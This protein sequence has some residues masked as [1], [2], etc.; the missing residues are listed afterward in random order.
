M[1]CKSSSTTKSVPPNVTSAG[2][3]SIKMTPEV[4]PVNPNHVLPEGATHF[5]KLVNS[6][7]HPVARM[8][9]EQ[10]S[11]FVHDQEATLSEPQTHH[12]HGTVTKPLEEKGTVP[13]PNQPTTSNAEVIPAGKAQSDTDG[14]QQNASSSLV[15]LWATLDP[16]ESVTHASVDEVGQFFLHYLRNDLVSRDWGGDFSFS[17]Q[18]L[19]RQGTLRVMAEVYVAKKAVFDLKLHYHA[20]HVGSGGVPA[21][22]VANNNTK[23]NALESPQANAR[24]SKA[25][26]TS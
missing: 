21:A 15:E 20:T 4:P 6:D 22:N 26:S 7:C 14:K 18:G 12:D 25:S 1:G 17:V 13:T 2:E 23:G 3:G 5:M 8:T 10:W 16:S 11:I 24:T 19:A 9:L